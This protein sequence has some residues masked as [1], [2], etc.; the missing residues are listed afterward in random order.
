M[1][2]VK[3][4]G[5]VWDVRVT[6]LSRNFNILYTENTQRTLAI[7][8]PLYLDP[9]GTFHGHKIKFIRR[10]SNVIEFDELYNYLAAP[11]RAGIP[12]ELVFGQ[13]TIAYEAYVSNGDQP[14]RLIDKKTGIVYWDEFEAN[15]IP[16]KAQVTP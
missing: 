3:I 12:V 1:D 15:I 6:E 14:L 5:R 16:L 8:A 7:G 2:Y 11:R 13:S 4:G 9:L 10:G